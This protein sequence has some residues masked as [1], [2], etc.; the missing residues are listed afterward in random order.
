MVITIENILT[1]IQY[2]WFGMYGN[3]QINVSTKGGYQRFFFH[4]HV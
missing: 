3:I 4:Y 2:V 1:I